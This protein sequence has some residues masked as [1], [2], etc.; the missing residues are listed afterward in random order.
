[1]NI[2]MSGASGLIGKALW[3]KLTSRGDNVVRLVRRL[4]VGTDVRWVPDQPLDPA[5]LANSDAV[6]HLSGKSI[7]GRWTGGAKRE[8]RDSRVQSTKTLATAAAESF[9][10]TG[11]PKTFLCASAIGYY[12][13]RAEEVLTE[14]S[15]PGTGFLPETCVAWEQAAEPAREAGVRVVNLRIGVVLAR[16]GG[17]LA[18]MMLPFKLGLG[19][20]IGTGRQFWSW[21]SLAD[22]IGAFVFTLDN[23]TL[24]GPV[25]VVAPSPVTNAEF[26][27]ALG[28]ALHRPVVMPLPAFAVKMLLGE[29][30]NS[31]LLDSTRVMPAKLEWAKYRFV[32]PELND[33]LV[34][35][36]VGQE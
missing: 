25:N 31:L 2:V 28:Q 33:A 36:L 22:V 18:S 32:H 35:A 16:D 30:G 1:M 20:R 11:N 5:V 8:I 21:V 6:V 24:Y 9:R 15:A 17:A 26:V 13:D 10:R 3:Q 7:A 34:T 19:G 4:P 27:E 14:H 12:G 29:M 23:D